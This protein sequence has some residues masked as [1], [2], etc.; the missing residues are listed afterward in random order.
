VSSHR[1]PKRLWERVKGKLWSDSFWSDGY[2]YRSIG[3]TTMD[4][5][6]YYIEHSQRRHW[7]SHDHEQTREEERVCDAG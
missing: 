6:Q 2:F 1:K 4:A 7:M 3:S 5:V